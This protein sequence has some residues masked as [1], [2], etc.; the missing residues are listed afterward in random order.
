VA[1]IKLILLFSIK[2]FILWISFAKFSSFMIEE[3][4]RSNCGMIREVLKM[5]GERLKMIGRHCRV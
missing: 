2:S 4:L 5:I 1:N 3:Y